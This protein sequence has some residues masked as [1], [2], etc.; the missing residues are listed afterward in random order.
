MDLPAVNRRRATAAAWAVA[1]VATL[2]SLS[3]S[4][5][6]GLAPCDLCWYQRILMYPL[7]VVLGYAALT[8]LP[9]VHRLV[10]PLSVPGLAIAAYHSWL[11]LSADPTCSFSGSCGVVQ[12]RLAGVLAI[13]NQSAVA[14]LLI[15]LAMVGSWW[16]FRAA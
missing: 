4:L 6:L 8:G 16:R 1:V 15:S 5:V 14:F 10:L 13:P 7:V 9:D 11:Q 3:Y 12:F 2:G